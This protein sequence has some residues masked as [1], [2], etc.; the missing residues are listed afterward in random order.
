MITT[1][2]YKVYDSREV[3]Y[4]DTPFFIGGKRFLCQACY[5]K[6]RFSSMSL[7]LQHEI[8]NSSISKLL[9]RIPGIETE[10]EC[11]NTDLAQL[12]EGVIEHFLEYCKNYNNKKQSN[13]PVEI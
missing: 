10:R 8:N 6:H 5:F 11:Y 2:S 7:Y 3:M 13:E 1:P 4:I 9:V 12:P